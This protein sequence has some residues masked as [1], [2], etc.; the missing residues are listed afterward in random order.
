[1]ADVV[2][3]LD[4]GTGGTRSLAVDLQGQLIAQTTR[5]YPLLTPLNAIN[6]NQALFPFVVESCAIA[7]R[8]K[9]E[10]ADRIGLPVGLPVVAGGGDNAA[11][12][13]GLG[14]C[15]SHLNRGNLSIGTRS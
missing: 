8:L 14:I 15:A 12:A 7:G 2:I 3:G 4:L 11:A 9:S 5:S 6:I 10:I 1:M 13:I